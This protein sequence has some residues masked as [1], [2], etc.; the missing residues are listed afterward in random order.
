[1]TAV[2]LKKLQTGDTATGTSKVSVYCCPFAPFGPPPNYT[3]PTMNEDGSEHLYSADITEPIVNF[4]VSVLAAGALIDPFVLGSKDEN[5]VQGYAGTPTDVNALTYDANVDIGAAGVQFP[6]LQRFYV[7]VDSRADPFTNQSQKGKYLLNAWTNDL[8]PPSVRLLTTRVSAGRPLIVAQAVDLQSGVDPASLVINYNNALVGASAYDPATGLVLFGIPTAAPKFK[9]GKTKAIVS[10]SDYQEAKNINTVGND[11]YPN[12]AFLQAKLTVVNG[13]D[14]DVGRAACRRRA[15]SRATVWWSSPARRRRSRTS[16]SVMGPPHRRRQDRPEQ[17]V[18]GRRG[19]TKALKKGTRRL[20]ATVT[21]AAGRTPAA[22]RDCSRSASSSRHRREVGHRRRAGACAARAWNARRRP[23]APPVGSRRAR[24]VRRRR[25]R[26]GRGAAAARVLERHPRIDLLV[27]NAGIGARCNYLEASPETIER[28][29]R[30]NYLGSVWSTLA[31]LPG[32]GQG[33]HL[34]N[35]VS[36]AGT[37]AVGPYSASKHAQLAFSRS[38]AVELAPRGISVHTVNPG[39]VETEG[40]PQRERFGPLVSRIVVDPPLVVERLLEAVDNGKREIFVPRWYRPAAWAQALAPGAIA[41]ARART[42]R[43]RPRTARR[44]AA[45]VLALRALAAC[46]VEV[47][48]DVARL[49]H[50][51]LTAQDEVVRVEES[52]QVDVGEQS[53]WSKDHAH[54]RSASARSPPADR[55]APAGRRPAS[56]RRAWSPV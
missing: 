55:W 11:I 41:S 43:R 26:R 30:V 53:A 21:D 49:P 3:G 36:V 18:L 23:L 52:A 10:A 37:V 54:A 44:E 34:V 50:D 14:G 47:R 48:L 12:T 56:C 1:M 28:V 9:A 32:L 39:F 5:D 25:P 27:N 31:F 7:A 33:S 42:S 8:T 51:L 29:I 15:R 17:C 22:S 6:R 24:G 35:V 4:G 2:P 16:R 45:R 46:E 20:V 40:F 13:P 19:S 38:L